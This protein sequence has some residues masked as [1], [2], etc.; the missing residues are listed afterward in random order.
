MKH[1]S[2]AAIDAEQR[3]EAKD[4]ERGLSNRHIQLIAIGGAI[5]VGLFLGSAKAIAKAGPALLLTYAIAGIAV[6]FIMRALGELLV[7]R[8]VAGSF[9]T[10][11]EEYISPWAGFVTGWTYWF[12]WIVTGMAELTAVGIYAHYWFPDI[13]QWL[14]ALLAL[15]ILYVANLIAVKLFG[16]MEFWFALVKVMAIVLLLVLGVGILVFGV[17]PLGQTASLSNLVS[18]GGFF[19]AGIVGVVF[20]LQIAMFAFT[21]VELIGVTAGEA[22]NPQEV[23]PK[24]TN[25][26]TYRILLFYIGSLVILMSL[27]AWNEYDPATSPFVAVFDKMGIPYAAGIINF[28]VLTA[29]AS[30]CNSGIFSTGRMLYTLAHFGQAPRMFG[31]VSKQHVPAKAI[32]VSVVMMLIGVGL[33]YLVPEEAFTYVTSVATVGAIWTWGVIMFAHMGYRK[34]VR[35]GESKPVAFRMPGGLFATGFVLLFLA[36][37]TVMLAFD[38]GN[39][40]ALYVAPVWFGLLTVGYLL[41]KSSSAAGSTRLAAASAR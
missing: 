21:G 24:A 32:S 19:P 35:L 26:I 25:S 18:H 6:F 28:V 29:A 30:S 11:A 38:A 13:P 9:A 20:T 15:G 8:P 37:G 14:P 10:Y 39:R 12:T 34:S 23:L 3:E 16:E 31:E 1:L 27:V 17:G 7:H 2:Q 22:D 33:N 41:S 5:G 40:V 4:L 36:A